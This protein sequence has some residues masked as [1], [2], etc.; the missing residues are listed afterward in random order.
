M[1]RNRISISRSLRDSEVKALARPLRRVAFT[2]LAILLSF[3]VPQP[4]VAQEEVSTN[5]SGILTIDQDLLFSRSAWG[6]QLQAEID[7]EGTELATENRTIEAE[8]TEEERQLTE[9]RATTEP[10]RFRELA[11]AFDEKV[12]AIRQRQ[13]QKERDLAR[14]AE[15]G[16]IAFFRAA[17]PVLASI[18]RDRGA[19]AILDSR[20]ILLSVEGIDITEEAI[21]RIDLALGSGA[22]SGADNGDPDTGGQG[23]P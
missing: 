8:L 19:V 15:E 20:A 14:R 18:V 1:T 3:S 2:V 23:D 21:T 9:L 7:I 16:R 10:E 4:A 6:Q 17:V 13:D 5:S 11:R 22:A 12:T